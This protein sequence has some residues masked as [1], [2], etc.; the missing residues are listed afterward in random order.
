MT[1]RG[2]VFLMYH[3]LETRGRPLSQREPGYVRY[4]VPQD[5]F[6]AQMNLLL[7]EGWKGLTTS[8]AL[9]N[10]VGNAVA[11]TFDDGCESDLLTAAP[12]LKQCRFNATL[13]VTAGFVGKPGYLSSA[14]LSELS[15]QGFEIGCHSMTHAYLNDLDQS[16]LDREISQAKKALEQIIGKRVEHFSCPGGRYNARVVDSVRAAGYRSLATS[17]AHANSLSTNSFLLGRVAVMRSFDAATFMRVCRG[18]GLARIQANALI[19][20]ATRRLLGNAFYD[21]LR[22]Q[23]LR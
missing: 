10:P 21:R 2:M 22:T 15:K 18:V 20:N 23:L 5:V 8:E 3:E 16:G 13:Y 6:R 7:Q 17:C 12:V 14:Q 11:I 4:V 1:S 19:R 9:A